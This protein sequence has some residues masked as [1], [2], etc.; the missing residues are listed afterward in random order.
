MIDVQ[1]LAPQ[2]SVGARLAG[3]VATDSCGTVSLDHLYDHYMT[4]IRPLHDHY[5]KYRL[6]L[7]ELFQLFQLWYLFQ[8]FFQG[9]AT[10]VVGSVVRKTSLARKV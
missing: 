4:T 6:I 7:D 5:M 2:P 10:G 1:V 8:Y 3:G 9:A